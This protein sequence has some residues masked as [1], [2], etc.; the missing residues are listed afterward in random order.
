VTLP[1][2]ALFHAIATVLSNASEQAGENAAAHLADLQLGA[3]GAEFVLSATPDGPLEAVTAGVAGRSAR[4][5]PPFRHGQK[6]AIIRPLLL[7]G[8][9]R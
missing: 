6:R 8:E 2:Y 3:D 5:L 7:L 9:I 1:S 4:P